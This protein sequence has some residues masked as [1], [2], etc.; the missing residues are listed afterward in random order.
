MATAFSSTLAK[1]RQ[2]K[3]VSQRKA[4]GDLGVSQAL[5]SHYE[6]GIRE[7]GLD[8]LCRACDY[9][10]VSS[11]YML[12]RSSQKSDQSGI[13]MRTE[14]NSTEFELDELTEID[15]RLL[16]DSIAV[17][18]QI[19][20]GIGDR[21]LVNDAF[22]CFAVAVYRIIRDLAPQEADRL[23]DISDTNIDLAADTAMKRAELGIVR[24]L[25]ADGYPTVSDLD[26]KYP[27]LYQSL[28]QVLYNA[29]MRIKK[30]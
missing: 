2:V 8:F 24:Q 3:G 26:E 9:Y 18:G 4:A 11:D 16:S 13:P 14:A 20:S 6:N 21:Q 27:E 10:Q 5:L 7:P 22:A 1:L 12:G 30:L 15:R 17:I 28:M 23:A 19:L 29:G 25:A